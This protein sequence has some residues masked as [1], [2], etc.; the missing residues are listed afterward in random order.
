ML[1]VVERHGRHYGTAT[2]Q[3]ST[4]MNPPTT[5]RPEVL[6]GFQMTIAAAR[7]LHDYLPWLV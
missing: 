4:R 6:R 3:D 1:A 5:R 7:Q 2:P